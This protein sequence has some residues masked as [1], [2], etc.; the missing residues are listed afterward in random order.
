M[1]LKMALRWKNPDASA[2]INLRYKDVFNKGFVD[3][4]DI[5]PSG[6]TLEVDVT[7]FTLVNFDGAVVVSDSTETLTVLDGQINYIVCRARYRLLDSPILSIESLTQAAY[8]AD[9]ELDWLHVVGVVDLSVGGPYV[10]VPANRVFYTER[11]ELDKQGRD[12]WRDPVATFGALPTDRNRDGDT[13]LVLDTGTLYWWDESALTWQIFDQVPIQIHRDREHVNGITGDS[14]ANTLE[15]TTVGTDL[16]IAAVPAGSAYTVDGRFLTVPVGTTTISAASVGA[17][18]G[19]IQAA[20]DSTGTAVSN[21]RIEKSPDVLDIAFCQI[22]DISDSHPLGTFSLIYDNGATTLTW[23]NGK[24]VTVSTGNSYRLYDDAGTGWIDVVL[25]GAAPGAL[26]S[27]NYDVN[28]SLKDDDHLLVGYWFWDGAAVLSNPVDRRIFGNLGFENLGDDFKNEEYYKRWNELRGNMVYS[29][30]RVTN[31]AGLSVRVEGPIVAY[32]SGVRYVFDGAYSSGVALTPLTTNYLY[33]DSNGLAAA[34]SLPTSGDYATVAEVTTD[35]GTVL[36]ITDARDP[37]LIVGNSTRNSVIK[38]SGARDLIWE[39]GLF[40]DYIRF[41]RG[42]SPN[43]T[44]L[45]AGA[46]E[47]VSGANIGGNLNVTGNINAAANVTITGNLEVQGTTTTTRSETVLISDSHL[48]LN[49]GYNSF[50]PVMGGLAVNLKI[51]VPSELVAGAYTS[52]T[53]VT[54]GSGTFSSGDL[55]AII[56]SDNNE[57]LFEVDSHVG[58]TL[59]IKGPGSAIDFAQTGF[60]AGASDSAVIRQVQITSLMTRASQDGW[61]YFSGESTATPTGTGLMVATNAGLPTTNSLAFWSSVGKI[62][63][64]SE[65]VWDGA[66]GLSVND[67]QISRTGTFGRNTAGVVRIGDGNTSDVYVGANPANTSVNISHGGGLTLVN[68]PMTAADLL[69]AASGII[70][71]DIWPA[72]FGSSILNIAALN[73]TILNLGTG[74]TIQVNIAQAGTPTIING[75]AYVIGDLIASDIYPTA[76]GSS[77]M[78]IGG[79]NTTTL[80]LGAGATTGVEIGA[81]T[82]TTILKGKVDIQ[83]VNALDGVEIGPEAN[84]LLTADSPASTSATSPAVPGISH[85]GL[86][87]YNPATGVVNPRNVNS[88]RRD[89]YIEKTGSDSVK[90]VN[91]ATVDFNERATG[92]G[93]ITIAGYGRQTSTDYWANEVFTFQWKYVPGSPISQSAVGTLGLATVSVAISITNVA[94]VGIVNADISFLSTLTTVPMVVTAKVDTTFLNN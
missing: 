92:T 10:F 89:Y 13:R 28:A 71:E 81:A 27:D 85:Y 21:Y 65:L 9:P 19:L 90:S 38:F 57:G 14:A 44:V 86:H 42:G 62:N 70:T 72:P 22:V 8:L 40:G 41:H 49:N 3:G 46:M 84:V 87:P 17:I 23:A 66:Q 73:T 64:S 35:A 55:V 56:G 67:T 24:P 29:G 52:S 80:Y 69:T 4:A 16:T 74:A 77:S 18:R 54:A 91:V 94:G 47:L 32:L 7:P 5:N 50:T 2:D 6:V 76:V 58:T 61:E 43:Y 36:T 51:E 75:L 88:W 20:F 11:H 31:L 53:V 48:Y 68:S 12:F 1:A 60:V 26:V 79:T 33:V 37:Q 59:T 39:H 34:T 83:K 15:P 25:T 45:S 63:Y 78:Q 93:T 30:G 82:K